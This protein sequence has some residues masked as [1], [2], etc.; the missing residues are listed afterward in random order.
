MLVDLFGQACDV[1]S[2]SDQEVGFSVQKKQ[3]KLDDDEM[4]FLVL[5]E[6]IVYWWIGQSS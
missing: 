5:L 2:I 4:D 1:I 3:L 6:I